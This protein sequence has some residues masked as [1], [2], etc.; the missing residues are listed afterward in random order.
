MKD[1]LRSWTQLVDLAR[2][3]S[4]LG[5]PTVS[6]E[7]AIYKDPETGNL[8][9]QN[10]HSGEWRWVGWATYKD[11]ETSNL[12][13]QN[14]HSGAWR[15]VEWATYKDPETRILWQ[16]NEYSGEWR[17][18]ESAHETNESSQTNEM[19]DEANELQLT[20]TSADQPALDPS[21]LDQAYPLQRVPI[22]PLPHNITNNDWYLPTRQ[23][24]GRTC[25]IL[26]CNMWEVDWYEPVRGNWKLNPIDLTR[27]QMLPRLNETPGC[28]RTCDGRNRV[29]GR[30]FVNEL[31]GV[32]TVNYMMRP[33][34][35]QITTSLIK[36]AMS[37]ENTAC[38][39]IYCKHGRHRSLCFA[40]CLCTW[41]QLLNVNV[42]LHVPS[43]D[44]YHWDRLCRG[45]RCGCNDNSPFTREECVIIKQQFATWER[46]LN[47][48]HRHA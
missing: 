12:W 13:Q 29:M 1:G 31:L 24:S 46:M 47:N 20:G 41:L 2:R 6:A 33:I 40:R 19:N 18:A 42:D 23:L 16:Q 43:R 8:W 5:P 38:L 15:W 45:R 11:I 4:M 28:R 44:D 17:W 25:S 7:W 9:Q 30:R 14:V 32:E 36:W 22:H 37:P 39:T 26:V 10:V 3:L 27:L 21:A 48:T 34:M 35:E